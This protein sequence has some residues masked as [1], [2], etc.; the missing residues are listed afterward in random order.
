MASPLMTP[1][2]VSYTIPSISSLSGAYTRVH[3]KCKL[4]GNWAHRIQ[5]VDTYEDAKSHLSQSDE[6]PGSGLRAQDLRVV[7]LSVHVHQA[8]VKKKKKKKKKKLL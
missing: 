2:I 4:H 3:M 6:E 1:G 5:K 8:P 7:G